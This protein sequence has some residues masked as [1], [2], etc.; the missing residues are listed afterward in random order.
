[1][2]D[3]TG[4]V[5]EWAG[6]AA[7]GGAFGALAALGIMVA[8]V[9][10]AAIYVYSSLAWMAIAKKLRYRYPWLAWIPF[11]N[12]AMILQLGGFNWA[13]AFLWLVPIL[14]WIAIGILLVISFWRIFEKRNYP[15]WL[16][17]VPL[18][19]L[20]PMTEGIAGIAFLI[21]LGFVAWK[22]RRKR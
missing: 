21:I 15:G 6:E 5:S 10:L 1:M 11:A 22:D 4:F 2:V 18:L 16:A 12:S 13:W 8:V 7:A 19:S 17:L 9:F 20:V 3:F 14:G